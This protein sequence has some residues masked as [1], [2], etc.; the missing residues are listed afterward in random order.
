MAR[1]ARTLY[2]LSIVSTRLQRGLQFTDMIQEKD[3]AVGGTGQKVAE[4][5]EQAAKD[6]K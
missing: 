2:G 1:L 4:K 6:S 3:G 5:A